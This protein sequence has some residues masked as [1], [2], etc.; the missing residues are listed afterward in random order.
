MEYKTNEEISLS[1]TGLFPPSTLCGEG[2]VRLWQTEV[3]AKYTGC[4]TGLEIPLGTY[5]VVRV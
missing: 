1:C 5:G 2:A 4:L 3:E